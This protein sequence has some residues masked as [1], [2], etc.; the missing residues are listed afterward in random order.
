MPAGVLNLVFGSG[1]EVGKALVCSKHV[2]GISFTG[3]NATGRQISAW[4]SQHGAKVQLEM[5]GK[6]PVIVLPDCNLDIDRIIYRS[7]STASRRG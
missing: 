5:G 6:N 7:T 2:D 3:S 1:S 4:A